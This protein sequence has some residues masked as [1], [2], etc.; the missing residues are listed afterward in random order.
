MEADM[1]DRFMSKVRRTQ[2]CWIWTACKRRGGYG[3]FNKG[4]NKYTSAHRLSWEIHRGQIPNKLSVLHKCN[5][6]ACVNPDHLYLGTHN[7]NMRDRV[8]CGRKKNY[9][10]EK[11]SQA[12]RT[13]KEINVIRN[14]HSN[15]VTQTKIAQMIGSSQ[16]YVSNIILG[17]VWA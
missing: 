7:D 15:G 17:R 9:R 16:G 12:K 3:H 5:N 4:N 14:W 6:A 8:A 13:L 10:G 1:I 11:N 2:D